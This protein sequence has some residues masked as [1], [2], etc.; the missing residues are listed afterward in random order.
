MDKNI[1]RAIVE[2]AVFLEYSGD[3]AINPDAAVQML[4][5]LAATL[6]VTDSATKL[7]LCMLFKEISADYSDDQ[8]EFVENL[9]EVL[10]LIEN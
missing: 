6:Q 1:A 4:E 10:G 5:Q 9:G 7:A 2:T 8:A 3:D